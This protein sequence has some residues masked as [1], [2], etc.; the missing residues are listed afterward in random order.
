MEKKLSKSSLIGYLVA[1]LGALIFLLSGY[2][3]QWGWWEL[4]TAFRTLI[5]LG[6]VLALI[7]L[8]S[9]VFG[10]YVTQSKEFYKGMKFAVIGIVFGG[11]TVGTFGYWYLEMQKYPPIHDITTDLE[12]PPEFEAIVEL[13]ADA[14]NP[15]EYIGEETPEI[16]REHYPDI[17]PLVLDVSLDSAFHRALDAAQQTSWQIVNVDSTRRIIEGTHKLAW[18]GFKDDV[19]IRVDTTDGGSKIDMRSKSRMGRGDI[20]VNAHRIRGYMELLESEN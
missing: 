10:L 16:Q 1:I 18:Y 5:P 20:G 13:R 17:Q 4:G 9:C 11:L 2:G 8:V 3:Y 7:G 12:D 6:A 19:V 14:P 15:P